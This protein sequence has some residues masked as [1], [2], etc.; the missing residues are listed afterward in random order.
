MFNV[1]E[2]PPARIQEPRY[3]VN[4]TLSEGCL[5]KLCTS[6]RSHRASGEDDAGP[7]RIRRKQFPKSPIEG[8]V[9]VRVACSHTRVL[10]ARQYRPHE[11][12]LCLFNVQSFD[13]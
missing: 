3:V 10:A 9:D 1:V 12:C 2:Y 4:L 13:E 6:F 8:L 7:S 11:F 5:A